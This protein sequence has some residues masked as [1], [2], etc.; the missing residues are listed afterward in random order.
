[1]NRR[2]LQVVSAMIIGSVVLTGCQSKFEE[3]AANGQADGVVKKEYALKVENSR[4]RIS[5]VQDILHGLNLVMTKFKI[6]SSK[7][8][9]VS[10]LLEQILEVTN[11]NQAQKTS[12]GYVSEGE[13]FVNLPG[14]D[15]DCRVIRARSVYLE[16]KEK[17]SHEIYV[18]TCKT[19][20]GYQ[21]LL[22]I[23]VDDERI[24]SVVPTEKM[25]SILPDVDL[26]ELMSA[27]GCQVEKNKETLTKIS[28]KS[29]DLILNEREK[30]RFSQIQYQAKEAIVFVA[31]GQLLQDGVAKKNVSLEIDGNGKP[32]FNA[33][34]AAN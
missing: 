30:I 21:K 9:L 17:I 14:L 20:G 10:N 13:L 5:Q 8:V 6:Q 25:E 16:T 28:C 7:D 11:S 19:K 1:M 31:K 27:Q 4:K 32:T 15:Q 24:T 3:G 2:G 29:G 26:R 34:D 18:Q 22:D 33:S 23:Q 12:K